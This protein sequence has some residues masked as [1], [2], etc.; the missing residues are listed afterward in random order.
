MNVF[1]I[2]NL[3]ANCR[4][5]VGPSTFFNAGCVLSHKTMEIHV[6]PEKPDTQASFSAM[7]Q[8]S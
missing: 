7:K 8:E 4:S 2:T 3:F 6:S 5:H 1:N